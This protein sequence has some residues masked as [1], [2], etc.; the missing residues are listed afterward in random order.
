MMWASWQSHRKTIR[1]SS[2]I[3][4]D[5]SDRLSSSARLI[6]LSGGR[7]FPLFKDDLRPPPVQR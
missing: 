5:V 6:I 7:R 2:Q 1:K 4:T 3:L